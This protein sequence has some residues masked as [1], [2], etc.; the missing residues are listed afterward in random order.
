MRIG[1]FGSGAF[2]LP[3]LKAIMDEHELA[4]VVQPA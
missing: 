3:T 2:G 1:F 4:F